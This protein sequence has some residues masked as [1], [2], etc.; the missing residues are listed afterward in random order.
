MST[1]LVLSVNA[2]NSPL[3]DAPLQSVQAAITPADYQ[4]I[5]LQ[6]LQ[7]IS[8]GGGT[9][10]AME[11]TLHSV[12]VSQGADASTWTLAADVTLSRMSSLDARAVRFE[13]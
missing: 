12:S 6:L 4:A 3:E 10:A 9:A 11:L 2:E 5:L 13:T 1:N 8:S 7:K